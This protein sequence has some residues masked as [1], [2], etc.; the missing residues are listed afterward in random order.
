MFYV[1]VFEGASANPLKSRHIHRAP[2]WLFLKIRDPVAGSFWFPI[3]TH[4]RYTLYIYIYILL[5]AR[6]LFFVLFHFLAKCRFLRQKRGPLPVIR[7]Q[8]RAFSFQTSAFR[9]SKRK[10]VRR[11]VDLCLLGLAGSASSCPPAVFEVLGFRS[12][13]RVSSFRCAKMSNELQ[14][15]LARRERVGRS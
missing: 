3:V 8:K 2:F 1:C 9:G 10:P 14:A 12:E 13:H 7:T 15:N 4:M 5:E 6:S 11:L